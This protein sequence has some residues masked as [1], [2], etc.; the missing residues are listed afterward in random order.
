M[1]LEFLQPTEV[2]KAPMRKIL[3]QAK[4][5]IDIPWIALA[6]RDRTCATEPNQ[7][8]LTHASGAQFLFISS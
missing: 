3:T 4:R 2:L 1:L 8:M 5:D 6:M 7:E